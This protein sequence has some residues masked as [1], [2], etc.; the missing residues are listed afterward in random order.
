MAYRLMGRNPWEEWDDYEDEESDE[1]DDWGDEDIAGSAEEDGTGLTLEQE[2][3]L[4]K[5]ADAAETMSRDE[6]IG[7]LLNCWE[8]RMMEKQ[9]F[10]EAAH[11]SGVAAQFTTVTLQR[12]PRTRKE[13][14]EI[15][16]Y[17]PTEEEA[18]EY[19][20]ELRETATMELNMERIVDSVD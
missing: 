15:F 6:L 14:T 1:L 9:L 13:F 10:A 19:L 5:I 7:A 12:L 16:G 3:M 20:D 4:R 8:Q 11:N 2:L 18:M 17:T